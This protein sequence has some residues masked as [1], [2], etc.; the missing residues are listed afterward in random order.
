LQHRAHAR[1]TQTITLETIGLFVTGIDGLAV[2][3]MAMAETM[4]MMTKKNGATKIGVMITNADVERPHVDPRADP[5]AGLQVGLQAG[6]QEDP[7]PMGQ[8]MNTWNFPSVEMTGLAIL[9]QR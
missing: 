3:G 6:L 5:L 7:E 2:E 4:M 1:R 8:T 9:T